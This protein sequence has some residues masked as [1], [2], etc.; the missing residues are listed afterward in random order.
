MLNSNRSFSTLFLNVFSA[1]GVVEPKDLWNSLQA[2]YDE[3]FIAS[4]DTLPDLGHLNVNDIGNSWSLET[5]YPVVKVTKEGLNV[6]LEQTRFQ[7]DYKSDIPSK[8]VIP[9]NYALESTLEKDLKNTQPVEF[10]TQGSRTIKVAGE[11][12]DFILLN[13]QQSGTFS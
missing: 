5:G 13:N 6:K 8:W 9:I 3:E 10:L 12:K 4:P 2:A 7:T 11:E 1:N